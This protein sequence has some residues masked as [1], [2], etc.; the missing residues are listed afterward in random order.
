M[1]IALYIYTLLF[2]FLMVAQ[3][4]TTA[5][6]NTEQVRIGGIT[7]QLTER[8]AQA[9]L[10]LLLYLHGGPGAA[11][12]AHQEHISQELEKHFIVVHWDQRGTKYSP[13]DTTAISLAVMQQDAEEVMHYLLNKYQQNKLYILGNS[14][15]TVLGFH[16]SAAYPEKIKAFFAVS[17]VIDNLKSQQLLQQQL[18]SHYQHQKNEQALTELASVNI[19]Y[20]TVNDLCVQ[21]KWQADFEG[22]PIPDAHYKG[23]YSYFENW[24]KLYLPLYKELYAH[25]IKNQITR[26]ECPLI[27][28]AGTKDH[29]ANYSVTKNFF[30]SIAVAEKQWYPFENTGHTIPQTQADKMQEIVINY[31]GILKMIT[32][33]KLSTD[34]KNP[35]S[36]ISVFLEN[37]NTGTI[38]SAISTTPSDTVYTIQTP[39]KIASSTKL[40]VATTILQLVEEGKLQLH[41]KISD[42]LP[43]DSLQIIDGKNYANTIT[44][45]QLLNHTSGLADLFTDK[46]EPFLASAV[47]N[48]S[49]QYTPETIIKT[50]YSYNLHRQPHS[51]PG[52]EFYYSDMNYV[53]LGLLIEQLDQ[54]PLAKSIRTRILEPLQMQHTY[55]Q[56]YEVPK[57]PETLLNQFVGPYNFKDINTSFDWAG[58]GLVA[59]HQDLVTFIKALFTGDILSQESIQQMMTT[60]ETGEDGNQYGL[61]IYKTM[62]NG[63]AFYGHYGFYGTYIGYAPETGTLVSY[64]INQAT[65]NFNTYLLLNNAISKFEKR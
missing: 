31:T 29:T 45:K 43:V 61:G 14:W 53:L 60:R 10:P 36:T 15:G 13:N 56:Y 38:H 39:F 55:L 58:G 25:P 35:T 42:F 64:C 8:G 62:Y 54:K 52:T 41:Q 30:D 33:Q 27:I 65:P 28:M 26:L 49:K 57:H 11:T 6:N 17:P 63:H 51:T 48:P 18:I 20:Q 50:Y 40:F 12:S 19:P 9:N 23:L 47:A 4:P 46:A 59:T 16:L 22:N 32:K 44:I 21:Y 5:V 1:K 24:G 37:K 2:S 34:S 3:T 7:Q